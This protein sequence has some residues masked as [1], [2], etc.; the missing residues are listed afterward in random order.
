MKNDFSNGQTTQVD[1]I[2]PVANSSIATLHCDNQLRPSMRL[3]FSVY[4]IVSCLL[5]DVPEP[6]LL[7]DFS[8][9]VN[10]SMHQAKHA[11]YSR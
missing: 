5:P 7:T 10:G 11:K 8:M 4:I 9:S 3:I 1:I 6:T 2:F